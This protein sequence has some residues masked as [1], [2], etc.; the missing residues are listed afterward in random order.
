MS[1]NAVVVTMQRLEFT[2]DART[3][4]LR[5]EART[6]VVCDEGSCELMLASLLS[7]AHHSRCCQRGYITLETTIPYVRTGG[8]GD[9][10]SAD[11]GRENSSQE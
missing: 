8:E 3:R 4:A 7:E 5:S 9:E 2:C 1:L 6:S 11:F 10:R